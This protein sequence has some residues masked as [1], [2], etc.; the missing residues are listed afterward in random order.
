MVIKKIALFAKSFK[1]ARCVRRVY[2]R[3]NGA[4]V[5]RVLMCTGRTRDILGIIATDIKRL[6]TPRWVFAAAMRRCCVIK[7]FIVVKRTVPSAP[8]CLSPTK[9]KKKSDFYQS[10]HFP[11]V[12]TT[13]VSHIQVR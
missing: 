8:G 4:E 1:S 10:A 11:G 7:G 12:F 6:L 2:T 13:F 5:D 9:K 3:I